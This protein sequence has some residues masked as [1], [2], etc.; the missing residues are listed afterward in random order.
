MGAIRYFWGEAPGATGARGGA[1][2][3]EERD[4]LPIERDA[5]QRQQSLFKN[6][7]FCFFLERDRRKNVSKI[8]YVLSS[9]KINILKRCGSMRLNAKKWSFDQ[10]WVR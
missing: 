10:V 9:I 1:E 7:F 5:N 6:V 4:P 3:S 2:R 8:K